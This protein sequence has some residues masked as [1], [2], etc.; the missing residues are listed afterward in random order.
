[1]MTKLSILVLGVTAITNSALA[2]N[3]PANFEETFSY[4][5]GNYW[6]ENHLS[7]ADM[8][9]DGR[10]DIVLMATALAQTNGPP[11][12][13]LSRAILLRAAGDG[14]FTDSVITNYPGRYGY[15]A[16]AAELN[17]DGSP[18][19]ILREQ[20]ATHVLLN[21]GHGTFREVWTGS[22]GYYNLTT[23]DVNRDGF[24]DIVSGTQTGSGGLIE[25]FTNSAAGTRF[26]RAWQS[27][28][29]G[30]GSDSIQTV[31]SVNLDNDGLPDI[32][33]R[34]I[35]GGR[36]V[37]LLGTAAGNSFVERQ[38]TFLGERTFALAAGRVNSDALDDLAATVGWGVVRVFVNRGD[39]S[40]SNY[41]ESPNLGQAA[42][43]LALADFDQD[44]FDDVFVGTFTDG[45][46]RI[47]R[48]HPGVGFDPWWE[49]RLPGNGYTGTSA[50]VNSDGRLDL[51]VGEK[52]RLRVLLN[53]TG[54]PRLAP[55]VMTEAGALLS[56]TALPGKTYRAQFKTS[57][58]DSAW[59]DVDGDVTATT[60]SASK[61]DASAASLSPRFYRVITVFRN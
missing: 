47:Y 9:G 31:L 36:M 40:M 12:S 11:W 7:V 57:L 54:S 25:L 52:N 56:W 4:S 3:A 18:D 55:L 20:T 53:Q 2:A 38:E 39:G 58:G 28:Y 32:A 45:L 51:I 50:D 33:A 48:N 19:L 14:S 22:P 41:W 34:E 5:L 24:L 42:F 10:T 59:T 43:G 1:M 6:C 27:R 44:G 35:Y 15:G 29:Y 46:L 8:D 13:Y 37:T 61:L 16:F 26:T 30:S 17:N 21:D 49:S 23:L 60:N